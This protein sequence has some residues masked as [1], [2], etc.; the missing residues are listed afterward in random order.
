VKAQRDL[1]PWPDRPTGEELKRYHLERF[2]NREAQWYRYA[3]AK[4]VEWLQ[5]NP[6]AWISSDW[7]WQ[8]CPPPADAHPSIMGPVFRDHRFTHMGYTK[9][10][11]ASAHARVISLYALTEGK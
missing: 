8:H 6:G 7:V 1:F 11:R 3:R 4:A 2:E 5:A 9:S 10:K